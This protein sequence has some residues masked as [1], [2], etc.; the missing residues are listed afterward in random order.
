[1]DDRQCPCG[2]GKDLSACCGPVLKDAASA[3]TPEEL[4]R[5]RYTAHV[6]REYDFLVESMHPGHR[7]GIDAKETEEW[8]GKVQW[9]GLEVFSATPGATD[10]E[11]GVSFAAHFNVNGEDREFRED[12]RFVRMD[13]RWYYVDGKVHGHETYRRESPRV[14]RNEPCP[15]GSGKKYKKCCGA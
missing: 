13:G 12:A 2:S 7:A 3:R 9:S 8:S 4:M 15:C 6:L 5:A 10:D 11:G 14:G 1:M